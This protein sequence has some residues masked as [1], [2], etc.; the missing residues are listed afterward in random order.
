[1]YDSRSVT[2]LQYSEVE[3]HPEV[4]HARTILYSFHEGRLVGYSY[5]S[6]FSADNTDFD[7][8]AADRLVKGHTTEEQVLSLLGR[9]TGRSIYPL[10]K[11]LSLRSV[12]YNYSHTE[13]I[14]GGTSSRTKTLIVTFDR[15]GVVIEV[16]LNVF[17][18]GI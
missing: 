16:S 9:P 7:D 4:A 2:V 1:M 3:L 6:S 10:V 17:P 13:R 5:A 8:S 11:E 15:R 14:P 18:V 12:N